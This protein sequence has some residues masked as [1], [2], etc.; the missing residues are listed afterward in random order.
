MYKHYF[1]NSSNRP[2]LYNVNNF[3]NNFS[4][5]TTKEFYLYIMD[6]YNVDF[7][8]IFDV[9][10][11]KQ[12]IKR[13]ILVS[14]NNYPLHKHK[15]IILHI[16]KTYDDIHTTE[17]KHIKQLL[18]DQLIIVNKKLKNTQEILNFTCL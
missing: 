15:Y 8:D 9:K 12:D 3:N 7:M 6:K 2:S 1:Y 10:L 4:N 11:D 14:Y 13:L 16:L 17:Y 5:T 18:T